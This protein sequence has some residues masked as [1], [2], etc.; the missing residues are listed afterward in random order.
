VCSNLR[1][2]AY[3][4]EL[5]EL[6]PKAYD[7]PIRANRS[8]PVERC[9]A[10]QLKCSVRSNAVHVEIL[11]GIRVFA[12]DARNH[13][14]RAGCQTQAGRIR[15][16]WPVCIVQFLREHFVHRGLKNQG[17]LVPI[18]QAKTHDSMEKHFQ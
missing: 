13:R 9:N 12:N 17:S 11:N 18:T 2:F 14:F 10:E 5:R 15:K 1:D 6:P 7:F 4:N 8:R 3:A 16:V